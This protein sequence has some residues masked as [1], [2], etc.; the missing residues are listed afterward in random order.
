MYSTVIRE[1]LL[2]TRG[3]SYYLRLESPADLKVLSSPSPNIEI[4][5]SWW[6]IPSES[7]ALKCKSQGNEAFRR[8]EM[9]LAMLYYHRALN[10][11]P[12]PQSSTNP[13][14]REECL[15]NLNLA[16]TYLRLKRP[17]VA[18]KA[19]KNVLDALSSNSSERVEL[20]AAQSDKAYYRY[21]LALYQLGHNSLC[22]QRCDHAKFSDPSIRQWQADIASHLDLLPKADIDT[23]TRMKIDP[24]ISFPVYFPSS[25]RVQVISGKGRGI[26]T[27]VTCE[28]DECLMSV[29]VFAIASPPPPRSSHLIGI[30]CS[31]RTLESASQVE[32]VNEIIQ[33]LI[34]N[35][36]FRSQFYQLEA[37]KNYDALVSDEFYTH[38]PP[39]PYSLHAD[40][41]K[42][43]LSETENEQREREGRTSVSVD[44]IPFIDVGR[45]E[46]IAML[47]SFRV[48]TSESEQDNAALGTS[49]ISLLGSFL[50]HSCVPN[51]TYSFLGSNLIIRALRDIQPTEEI[52]I[53]Y[54]DSNAPYPLR[55]KALRTYFEVCDCSRCIKDR[56]NLLT[57]SD[58]GVAM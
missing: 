27:S 21:A 4:P 46:C 51:A 5:S 9:H 42:S 38:E 8:G 45:I 17:G 37:G 32:L 28:R 41:L 50:N 34:D 2:Q 31:S 29:P 57:R 6:S 10:L 40:F 11:L 22:G 43:T 58:N 39:L 25:L 23:S 24:T 44:D 1:P 47:N 56:G 35:P 15:I 33:T 3:E 55:A 14:S 26:I 49:A 54:C 20:N 13:I 52:T 19:S 7:E 48:R 12:D 16:E 36:H 53:S 30:N 18:L